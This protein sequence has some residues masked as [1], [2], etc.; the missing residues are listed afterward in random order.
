MT[1]LKEAD[2]SGEKSR[3]YRIQNRDGNLISNIVL[4]S[5]KKLFY[6]PGHSFHRVLVE[7]EVFLCPV[8]GVIKDPIS[9]EIIGYCVVSW[10]PENINNPVQF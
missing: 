9:L 5:P 8:P 2:L 7:D 6:G 1:N 4:L 3:T 10:V